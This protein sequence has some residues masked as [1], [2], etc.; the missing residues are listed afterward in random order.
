MRARLSESAEKGL[1]G[2][3]TQNEGRHRQHADGDGA[4]RPGMVHR[5]SGDGGGHAPKGAL[6]SG[7]S[8]APYPSHGC[9][10]E[11]LMRTMRPRSSAT[12]RTM[13][14]RLLPPGSD[15]LPL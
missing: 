5:E 4:H 2:G 8:R 7:P 6:H 10:L 13:R 3:V 14:V 1:C 15:A 12:T 9:H 11:V